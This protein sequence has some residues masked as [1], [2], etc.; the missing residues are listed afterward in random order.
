MKVSV[1]DLGPCRKSVAVELPPAVIRDEYEKAFRDFSRGVRLDG[2]RKGKV[3]K[4]VVEQRFGKEI[5]QEVVEHLIRDY[6]ASALEESGLEPLHTPILKDYKFGR[7]SGL[8]FV[9]EF[10]VRPKIVATGYRNLS[11]P[12]R[13]VEVKD[14]D[15][16]AALEDLRERAARYE[17]VE[18]RGVEA[19]DHILAD[20]TGTIEGT[21]HEPFRNDDVF[22]EIGSAGPHPELTDEIRGMAPGGERTFGI[23]YPQDHPNTGFAGKRVVYSIR[24]KEIKSKVL[25]ELDD[26]FAKT[27]GSTDTLASF[28]ERVRDDLQ[29]IGNLRERDE[30]RRR[31]LDLVLEAN[32]SVEVPESLIDDQVE[33][34]IEDTIRSMS[35]QGM[36]PRNAGVDW[37]EIRKEHREPARRFVRGILLLDAVGETEKLEVGDGEIDAALDREAARRKTSA[38]A[39]RARWEKEGRLDS[40]KRQILREKVLDFLLTPANI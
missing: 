17:G 39:L 37:D 6:S 16:A 30:A 22:F 33:G 25:P 40:L 28:R 11:V 31:A 18:G 3:P 14:A 5:E 20:V 4:H 32:A 35:S 8:S 13:T 38:D 19:G 23:L 34:E 29:R 1:T 15:V 21:D 26:E 36:D 12:R 7:E 27:V 10:E 24:L 9:T 2:F